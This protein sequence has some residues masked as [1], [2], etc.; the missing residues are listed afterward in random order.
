MF[1]RKAFTL[2]ELLVVIAIIAILAAI[3]F[4]VFASAK[5]A[6]KKTTCA[7]NMRQIGL[8]L[9]MYSDDHDGLLP[10]TSHEF[11]E[12][13]EH[14]WVFTLHSY[15]GKSGDIRI[16]PA[17]PFAQERK[18]SNGT[19][20]VLN[21]WLVEADEEGGYVPGLSSLPQPS[22]T[23]STFIISDEQPGNIIKD[24]THSHEWFE[25]PAEAWDRILEDIQPDR[26]RQGR[27]TGHGNNRNEGVANYLY[28]DG[29]V[30]AMPAQ[31]IR[32]FAS[33]GFD[34]SRPPLD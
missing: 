18:L 24:H 22:S 17:D 11:G 20:Y 9:T 34:F 19:S 33:E 28:C 26:F 29:H 3:L 15:L 21:E 16:C 32:G 4:P 31:K 23:I 13:P 5:V 2:I 30:K 14:S 8:G 7:S 10:L 1:S 25:V 12:D 6:A 27:V